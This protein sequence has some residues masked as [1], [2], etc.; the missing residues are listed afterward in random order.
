MCRSTDVRNIW[1]IWRRGSRREYGENTGKLTR[2][3]SRCQ[4][5][6]LHT[7]RH[8]GVRAR[9]GRDHAGDPEVAPGPAGMLIRLSAVGTDRVH[10]GPQ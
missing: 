5:L 6:Q 9:E 7:R 4:A 2:E 8:A 1:H 3:V 10:I